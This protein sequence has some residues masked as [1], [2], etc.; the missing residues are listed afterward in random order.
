MSKTEPAETVTSHADKSIEQLDLLL[1]ELETLAGTDVS[2]QDFYQNLLDQTVLAID[3]Q[4]ACV[5]MQGPDNQWI[6]IFHCQLDQVYPNLSHTRFEK[7]RMLLQDHHREK[8]AFIVQED[9]SDYVIL[10]RQIEVDAT[11]DLMLAVYTAGQNRGPIA[12]STLPLVDALGEIVLE[13]ERSQHLRY[14]Q[15]LALEKQNVHQFGIAIHS[16]RGLRQVA[17]DVVNDGIGLT[18]CQRI[19]VLRQNSWGTQL[20]ATSGLADVDSRSNIVRSMRRLAATVNRYRKPLIWTSDNPETPK[21]IQPAFSAYERFSQPEFIAV[22]PVYSKIQMEHGRWTEK[23]H[24][25]CTIIIESFEPVDTARTLNKLRPFSEQ[26]SSGLRQAA[27]LE[28]IPLRPLWNAINTVFRWFALD[29]IPKTAIALLIVGMLLLAA[30]SIKTQWT[31]EIRG[32]LKPVN[33][34]NLFAPV[35]GIVETLFVSHGDVIEKGAKVL[36][37]ESPELEK[38]IARVKG[39]VQTA[40]K[41]LES[42]ETALAQ[43]NSLSSED[44]VLQSRLASELEEQKQVIS[45]LESERRFFEKRQAELV[46]YSN[47]AGEIVTWNLSQ[48]LK[49]RPVRRGESLMKIANINGEWNIEFEVPDQKYGYLKS[50][51]NNEELDIEFVL[52]TN[53]E[54]KHKGTI[55]AKANTSQRDELNRSI[56]LVLGEFDRSSIEQLRPG[57][58]VTARVDC[59]KKS[60]AYVW[61]HEFV[62]SIKRRF[63]W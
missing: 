13:F 50:A 46:I 57:A 9:R 59:G 10:V 61:T 36:Q 28:S 39:D 3:A 47:V 32:E 53:P 51:S 21:T 5:L 14:A 19:T 22:L 18:G 1:D 49:D 45:N 17:Y 8:S 48:T 26:A 40:K 63:F 7:D 54:E 29:R 62:D 24:V 12:R 43:V 25:V 15:E 2:R 34:N 38:E 30:F 23:G 35:D 41:K 55:V 20:L 33:A 58:V 27:R 44:F 60:I 37:L 56:V 6:P 42:I 52:A 16:Y 4:A 11:S 31:V